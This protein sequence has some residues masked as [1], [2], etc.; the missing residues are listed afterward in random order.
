MEVGEVEEVDVHV[1]RMKNE[2]PA[3]SLIDIAASQA[4]QLSSQT[5]P[6]SVAL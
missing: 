2:E 3:Q 1:V 5:C 6:V 4:A